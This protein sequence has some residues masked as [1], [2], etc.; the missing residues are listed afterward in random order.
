LQFELRDGAEVIG[1]G[2][3]RMILSNLVPYNEE[4]MQGMV[5]FYNE[6]KNSFSVAA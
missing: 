3:K 6:R 5:D 1:K 2:E 4:Q